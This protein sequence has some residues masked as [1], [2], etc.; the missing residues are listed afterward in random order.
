MASTPAYQ[1]FLT[2]GSRHAARASPTSETGSERAYTATGQLAG[3]I[4]GAAGATGSVKRTYSWEAAT[5]RLTGQAAATPSTGATANAQNDTYTYSPTGDIT[6]ITAAFPSTTSGEAG[7]KTGSACS[8]DATGPDPYHQGYAYDD[9]RNLTG[10]TSGGVTSTYGYGPNTTTG[11]TGGPHAPTSVTRNGVTT[12]YTYDPAGN[13]IK[14]V[15]GQITTT[16]TWDLDGKLA[17][18][19]IGSGATAET[20]RFVEGPD[21][22]RWVRITKTE[23]VAYL[24]GQEIHLPAGSTSTS[25]WTGVRYYDL[26]DHTVATRT[27][28]DGAAP[29]PPAASCRGFWRTGRTPPAS[30]STPPPA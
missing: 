27:T 8:P 16:Y 15:D 18:M 17:G 4:L 9:D 10:L 12:T 11:V 30:P 1:E 2:S 22:T 5:G 6:K 25:A 3:R 29:P 26:D 20:S 14:R 21:D 13:L 7:T 28:T 24:D 19:T 23:T